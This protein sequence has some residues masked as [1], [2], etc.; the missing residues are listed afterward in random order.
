METLRAS[1]PLKEPVT[2]YVLSIGSERRL[3]LTWEFN[4][5][6]T[7]RSYNWVQGDWQDCDSV[8]QGYQER[9]VECRRDGQ[10]SLEADEMCNSNPKPK[11]ESRGCNT[12]CSYESGNLL[13]VILLCSLM[14]ILFVR[15]AVAKTRCSAT[16]G[17]GV[18]REVSRCVRRQA[19]TRPQVVT[20]EHCDTTVVPPTRAWTC[21][22]KACERLVSSAGEWRVGPWKLVCYCISQF[23]EDT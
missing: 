8:C 3:R 1:G 20:S 4:T 14:A 5:P 22:L 13:V 12:N 15:W 23:I 17:R 18:Q 2:L 16:C 21:E 10:V 19:G 11:P 7:K 9:A 6:V